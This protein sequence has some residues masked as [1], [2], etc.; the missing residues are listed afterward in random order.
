[1][2]VKD[3]FYDRAHNNRRIEKDMVAFAYTSMR[4]RRSQPMPRLEPSASYTKENETRAYTVLLTE[5]VFNLMFDSRMQKLRVDGNPA[6][7]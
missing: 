7:R 3:H 2:S 1:M 4:R 6:F 5:S